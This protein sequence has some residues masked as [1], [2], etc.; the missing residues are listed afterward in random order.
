MLTFPVTPDELFLER[1]RQL[2]S[3]GIPWRSIRR[4]RARIDDTWR[5]GPGGWT[6]EWWQEAETAEQAGHLMRA[7]MLY[8]AARFPSVATPLRERAL[9][10]QARCF[11]PA[12]LR[13]PGRF[14]R[15]H[16]ELTRA[17]PGSLPVH[18]YAPVGSGGIPLVLLSGGVDTGKMELHRLAYVLAHL[19]RFRV[20]AIDMPG[21]GE[22]RLPLTPDAE[23]I[24][25]ELLDTLAPTGPRAVF[26]VS[27]GGHW[28]AKLA[29]L[30]AVDAVVDLGGP[31]FETSRDFVVGLPNGMDGILANA[32]RLSSMPS[33]GDYGALI[34]PFS[35]RDQGLLGRDTCAPMLVINGEHDQYIPQEDSTQ[36]ARYPAN[37]VWLMRGM[38][39][40]AAEGLPRI[41]PSIVTWLRWKL[42]G[43]TPGDRMAF[44]LA[45]WLLPARR[46]G[47]A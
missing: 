7:A 31:I 5:E 13:L 21:T 32:L 14:E 17:G 9:E 33:P 45:Q 11:E 20:A 46:G 19:G 1:S 40:C 47:G 25:A 15:H 12:A 34:R 27:F 29:L 37:R 24:Y 16:V 8:G 6:Y 28:A 43:D 39:H 36:L 35:L 42:H 30:D 23:G 22:T 4:V 26:G 38:T 3:W 41:V 10:R 18:L 44:T 2:A